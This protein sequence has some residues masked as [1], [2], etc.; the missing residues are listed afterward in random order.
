MFK[1]FDSDRLLRERELWVARR[2]SGKMKFV[3]FNTIIF[4]NG[5]FCLLRAPVIFH[6]GYGKVI[7]H[8]G[9]VLLADVALPLCI[10]IGLAGCLMMWRRGERLVND[11]DEVDSGSAS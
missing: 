10:A 5:L 2:K 8:H 1:S 9:R 11:P 7:S 4:G 6:F 3:F